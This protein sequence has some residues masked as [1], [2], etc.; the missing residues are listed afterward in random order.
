VPARTLLSATFDFASRMGTGLCPVPAVRG[1]RSSQP[2]Q[3]LPPPILQALPTRRSALRSRWNRFAATPD[4]ARPF[5]PR[6]RREPMEVS[7]LH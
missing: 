1:G 5:L 2:R 6:H 4:N 7:V 3:L